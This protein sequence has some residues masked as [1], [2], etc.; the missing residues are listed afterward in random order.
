MAFIS[1]SRKAMPTASLSFIG[2]SAYLVN[3]LNQ[4]VG[5]LTVAAGDQLYKLR[6][7]G[8]N[9]DAFIP[10]RTGRRQKEHLFECVHRIGLGEV[11]E[12]AFA[13]GRNYVRGRAF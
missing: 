11:T 2:R 12:G 10:N 4:S 7:G 8:K 3:E 5:G 1:I 13:H 6:R 9:L